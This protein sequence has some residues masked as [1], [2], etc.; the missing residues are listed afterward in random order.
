MAKE[1]VEYKPLIY[2]CS[3][4][5]DDDKDC[6]EKTKSYCRFALECGAIPLAPQLMFSQFIDSS[7]PEEKE[8]ELFMKIVLMGKCSEVWVFGENYSEAMRV[9]INT[10]KKRRQPVR[11]FNDYYKEVDMT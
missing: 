6:V 3:L 8:L 11:Y 10:A 4:I 9:E 2:I 5:S 1:K 7:V